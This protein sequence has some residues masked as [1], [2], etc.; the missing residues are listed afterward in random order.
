MPSPIALLDWVQINVGPRNISE[1]LLGLDN[2]LRYIDYNSDAVVGVLRVI[3]K[4]FSNP[5]P[6]QRAIDVFNDFVETGKIAY[7]SYTHSLRSWQ[8]MWLRST[9]RC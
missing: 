3:K 7:A 2:P 9:T 8:R 1:T 5:Q 4:E 6:N